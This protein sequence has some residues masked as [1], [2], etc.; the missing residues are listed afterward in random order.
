MP[1]IA[2]DAAPDREP[3][4]LGMHQAVCAFVEDLGMEM[5][6]TSGKLQHKAVIVWEI[7]EKMT[8]GAPFT[9]SQRYTVSLNEKANLRKVLESWRGRPFT[10]EELDGFDLE[11]LIGANCMLNLIEGTSAQGKKFT[12]IASVSPIIKGMPKMGPEGK[13]APK[14]IAEERAKNAKASETAAV[15]TDPENAFGEVEDL[16]AAGPADAPDTS[17]P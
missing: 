7:N 13:E 16:V 8:N 17:F 2:K 4:P 1:L 10:A 12:K 11:K 15:A 6:P 14:W 3:I 5:N 9:V